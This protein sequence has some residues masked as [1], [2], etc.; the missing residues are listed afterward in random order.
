L[1]KIYLRKKSE[2]EIVGIEQARLKPQV[3]ALIR[4]I[5]ENPYQNPPHK[6]ILACCNSANS[7][8]A[9]KATKS[10][11]LFSKTKFNCKQTKESI[12]FFDNCA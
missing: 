6:V 9:R 7:S 2:T 12:A 8:A 10:D 1:Y 11:I 3:V 5:R 4:V